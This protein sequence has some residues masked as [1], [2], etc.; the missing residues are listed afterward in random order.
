M[1]IK[2]EG[3]D[4]AM[5]KL[6]ALENREYVKGTMQACVLLAKNHIAVYPPATEANS[7]SRKRWYE[8]GF[9]TRYRRKDGTIGGRRTSETLGRKWAT[10]VT[11]KGL[12]GKI[13]NNAS[14]A[15][16]VHDADKQARFHAARRWRTDKD[17]FA[18]VE[19]KIQRIWQAA[20]AKVM[21]G[22][23]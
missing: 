12:V 6:T 11:D 9:G 19:P 20:I 4:R 3:L 18:A 5:R 10:E 1:E 15:R 14:Y 22:T 16:F 13:G 23:K 2:I 8:R 21:E 17:T 7:P